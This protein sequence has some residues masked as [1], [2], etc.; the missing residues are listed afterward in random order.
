MVPSLCGGAGRDARI[1]GFVAMCPLG[2]TDNVGMPLPPELA[3]QFADFLHGALPYALQEQW[4]A[5]PSVEELRALRAMGREPCDAKRGGRAARRPPV[6]VLTGD[7]DELFTPEYYLD[8]LAD[9][10]AARG[11]GALALRWVRLARGDHALSAERSAAV[12]RVVGF[13][14]AAA[15]PR[16][17]FPLSLLPWLL[18]HP[19]RLAALAYHAVADVVPFFLIMCAGADPPAPRLRA[20]S[21][22]TARPGSLKPTPPHPTPHPN[23]F[24]NFFSSPPAHARAR[25]PAVSARCAPAVGEG[26]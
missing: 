6:L 16:P 7:R 5:L 14:L 20:H 18:R 2:G 26:G 19:K 22:P 17:P 9:P 11:P 25:L 21:G 1:Q 4:R 3:E 8:C 13:A 10:L 15:A 24:Y 23:D 12:R